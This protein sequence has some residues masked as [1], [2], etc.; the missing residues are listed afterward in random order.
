MLLLQ[1]QARVMPTKY[2][3]VRPRRRHLQ[4]AQVPQAGITSLGPLLPRQA[5]LYF[6]LVYCWLTKFEVHW[7]WKGKQEAF[8]YSVIVLH[9]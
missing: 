1:E 9:S 8:C 3:T 4:R 7:K 5:K 2:D 6:S